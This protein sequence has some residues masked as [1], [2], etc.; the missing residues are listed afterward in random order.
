MS[1]DIITNITKTIPDCDIH[2]LQNY[3]LL[4]I[5]LEI[6]EIKNLQEHLVQRMT[7]RIFQRLI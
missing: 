5:E 6:F 7:F 1:F 4:V 3:N 2:Y